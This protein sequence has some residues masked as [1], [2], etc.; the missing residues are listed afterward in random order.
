VYTDTAPRMEA[1]MDIFGRLGDRADRLTHFLLGAKGGMLE[2]PTSVG[3]GLLDG[4]DER[5]VGLV[6]ELRLLEREIQGQKAVL[7]SL[8]RLM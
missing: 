4:Q 8:G 5:I 1:H 6:E 2:L 3:R 7:A